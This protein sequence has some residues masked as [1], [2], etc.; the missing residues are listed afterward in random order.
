MPSDVK[1]PLRI[2]LDG[3][4]KANKSFQDSRPHCVFY[5]QLDICINIQSNT[6]LLF[7]LFIKY[8]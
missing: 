4:T 6:Q 8:S 2:W 1:W 7:Y 3:P 5:N